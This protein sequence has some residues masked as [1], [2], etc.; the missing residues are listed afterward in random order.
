MELRL[1]L[2]SLD[3]EDKQILFHSLIGTP[4]EPTRWLDGQTLYAV[5]EMLAMALSAAIGTVLAED[6]EDEVLT[7]TLPIELEIQYRPA[8]SW[9]IARAHMFAKS[10]ML[11]NLAG[12]FAHL[13]GQVAEAHAAQV[14]AIEEVSAFLDG[15]KT[16]IVYPYRELGAEA[17]VWDHLVHRVRDDT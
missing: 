13:A 2:R 4:N 12:V 17:D 14:Y 15:R 7:V 3:R 9:F 6:G 5:D 1:D 16:Q 8:F 10:E 11:E